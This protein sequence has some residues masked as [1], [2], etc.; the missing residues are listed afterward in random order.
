LYEAFVKH[1]SVNI[2]QISKDR[3]EQIANYRFL[4]N[5]NVTV[6][7]LTKSISEHCQQQ[8]SGLHVLA[9]SDTSEINLEKHRGRLK[10][11]GLG[12]VENNQDVGFLFILP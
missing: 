1:Q 8:V 6:S 10:E 2:R 3:A 11:Q 9:I 12:L 7:E 4:G 5:E